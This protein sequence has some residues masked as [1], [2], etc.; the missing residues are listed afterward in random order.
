MYEKFTSKGNYCLSKRAN[1]LIIATILVIIFL[2]IFIMVGLLIKIFSKGPV[3]FKQKRIG[4]KGKEFIMYKF[5]S[6]NINSEDTIHREYTKDWINN[7]NKSNHYTANGP[8]KKIVKDYRIIPYVGTFIRKTSL[9]ELP[10]LFNVI[11]GDMSLVGP[12]P[13]LDYEVKEYREWHKLRLN[14]VPGITGL[15]QVSGRNNLSFDEM[16]KLDI[17]YINNYSLWYDIRII[18]KTPLVM[19]FGKAH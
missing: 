7:T 2:P 1:D 12:R 11:K 5:R 14:G 3:F 15:W 19:L 6:M 18:F 8:V 16:V 13:G 17:H 9:D 10:Q 4:Y